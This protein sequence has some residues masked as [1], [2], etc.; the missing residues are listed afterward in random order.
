[1]SI[2]SQTVVEPLENVASKHTQKIL[3]LLLC[4]FSTILFSITV[5]KVLIIILATVAVT[6]IKIR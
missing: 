5:V 3:F 4:S 2:D 6:I 1:M